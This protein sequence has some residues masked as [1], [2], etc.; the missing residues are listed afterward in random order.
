M[1]I[2]ADSPPRQTVLQEFH[3]TTIGGHV[4]VARTYH[5]VASNF[6]WKGMKKNV[7]N[8]VA[9]RQ[10]CQQMKDSHQ[11]P[12]GVLQ[13]LPIPSM[14]FEE[15]AMDFITFF[16]SSKGMSTIMTVVDRLS[17]YGHF[18]VLSSSFPAQSIEEAFVIGIVRLHGPPRFIL[19]D[20]D[21]RFLHSFW[22]ELNRLQGTTFAMSTAYHPQRDGKSEALNKCME[23]YLRC[24]VIYALTKWVVILR[25][26]EYCYNS[27]Y[28]SSVGMT[29]FR[30]LYGRDRPTVARYTLGSSASEM[31]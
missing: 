25:W 28:Q 1:V 22:Q 31:I 29:P 11:L 19:S 14:V 21:L 12:A 9:S 27:A 4:G 16:P 10:V 18:I 3:D 20:R 7:Y 13:P 6:C 5:R 17:K 2:H 26:A 8:Y 23:K 30:V 24:F 15:I